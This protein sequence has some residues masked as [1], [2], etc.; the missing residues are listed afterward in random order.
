L[1]TTLAGNYVNQTTANTVR[2]LSAGA[3]RP[4]RGRASIFQAL[5]VS[6]DTTHSDDRTDLEACIA[7]KFDQQYNAQVHHF[8]P[9]LLSLSESEELGAVVGLRLAGQ[10]ELFLERYLDRTAEQAVSR[11]VRAPIDRGQVVEIGN[12]AAAVAG[13]ASLLFAV[14]AT[15]LHRA[16]IRWVVCTA[17]P[18]VKTMLGNMR[19]PIRTICDA[20]I[21]AMG[22]QADEWGNYYASRP[23]VIVGDTRHAAEAVRSSR[24]M[25]ALIH[26]LDTPINRIA[27]ALKA[28][29]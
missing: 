8:L 16:G 3:S 21:A 26:K 22:D 13:T 23:Q 19:F 11:T 28:A 29:R 15:I 6:L 12:L 14:L 20:N 24:L 1:L 9:H 4:R 2:I 25:S 27:A 10:S 17:T 5:A 7:Q 18:Q